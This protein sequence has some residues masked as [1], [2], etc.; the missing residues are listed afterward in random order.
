MLA[1]ADGACGAFIDV[2]C[3]HRDRRTL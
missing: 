2:Y 3:R 1:G